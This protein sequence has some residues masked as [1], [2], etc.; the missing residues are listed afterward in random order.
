[1][2]KVAELKKGSKFILNGEK[3][4]VEKIEFS[5]IGKL[6]KSKCRVEALNESNEKKVL[7]LQTDQDV[8][9]Q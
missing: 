5:K 4:T 6:G 8:E 9:L 3:L 7:I 1:M 2:T